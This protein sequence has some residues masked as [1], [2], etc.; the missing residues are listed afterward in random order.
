MSYRDDESFDPAAGKKSLWYWP[1]LDSLDDSYAVAHKSFGGWAFAV[2]LVLGAAI[3]YFSGKSA[4]NF[5]TTE[6]DVSGALIGIGIELL[7]VL[8]ASYRI[9][10]GKGWIVAWLLFALFCFEAVM[11]VIGGGAVVIGWIFF[12]I[13]VGSSILAGARA[14]WDIRSRRRAGEGLSSAEDLQ[15]VF[16]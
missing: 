4:I 15:A 12:Y 9:R 8:F 3:T 16:E 14:C 1:T 11:K 5:R 6:T 2:M 10:S 13:A 7:F